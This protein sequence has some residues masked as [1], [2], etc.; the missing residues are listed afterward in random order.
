MFAAPNITI[1]L[2]FE[3]NSECSQP[4]EGARIRVYRKGGRVEDDLVNIANLV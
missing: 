3:K 1:A 2:T 4:G